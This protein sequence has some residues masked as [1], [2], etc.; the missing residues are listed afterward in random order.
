MPNTLEITRSLS[1]SDLKDLANSGG[2]CITLYVPLESAP[3]TSRLDFVRLKGMIRQASDRLREEWPELSPAL[4]RE[5]TDSLHQV[6]NDSDGWGGEGGSLVVLRS[7]DVFRVAEVKQKLEESVVIGESFHL[8][9]VIASLQVA[10]RHFYLLALSQKHVRLLRCTPTASQ[11]VELPPSVPTSLE[12]W[13]T[14]RAPNSAPDHG[15]GH[16]AENGATAGNF[17]STTDR[18]NK[19][20]HIANF[21]RVINKAVFDLL[22]DETAPLVLCGVEYERAT[23]KQI[24]QY[25]HLVEEGVQGSPESLKGGEMHARAFEIALDS[26]AQPARKALE[27]WE[28]LGGSQ[29]VSSNFPDI[30]KAAFQARIATLFCA[31]GART[32]GVF[33]RSTLE[34][35]VQG[36]HEDL[37]NASALQTLAFGGDVFILSPEHMPGGGQMNA[38]Y[39]F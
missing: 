21:F 29:R 8:F 31:E 39:R 33:D 36:R 26:F 15:A 16:E 37:V 4:S 19:D 6:E 38:I 7:P 32:A 20:Q 17:T 25:P 9:P 30:V 11:E 10:S 27:Q 24:N 13:L 18:D 2:P 35:K 14:T 3:N 1:L 22:R 5:L 34:M 23:Y 12:A 28:K